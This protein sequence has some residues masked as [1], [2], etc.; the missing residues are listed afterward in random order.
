MEIAEVTGSKKIEAV[1]K[2]HTRG[3]LKT[4]ERSVIRY[5]RSFRSRWLGRIGQFDNPT[6]RMEDKEFLRNCCSTQK[7]K[8]ANM[9]DYWLVSLMQEE[10]PV[11]GYR[12]SYLVAKS[13]VSVKRWPFVISGTMILIGFVFAKISRVPQFHDK[14]VIRFIRLRQKERIMKS[15]IGRGFQ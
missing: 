6:K 2:D 11:M 9:K 15:L 12:W 14:E 3:G 4:Y 10:I 8:L 5:W 1:E 13:L 7:E